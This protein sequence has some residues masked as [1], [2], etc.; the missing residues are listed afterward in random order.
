MPDEGNLLMPIHPMAIVDRQAEID[1]SADI[2]PY[3][4]IDGPVRIGP[5]TRVYPHAYVSGWTQIGAGCSIHPGA[6]VGHVP[7]DLAYQNERSFCRIGDG[8]IIREGAS[9]HRGTQRDSE[10]VV[11]RN[12]FIM[13]NAHV[14]HNCRVGDDVKMANAAVLAGH[15]TVGNGVFISSYGGI[16]QF[17]RIGELV[18]IASHT[19]ILMDVPPYFLAAGSGRCRGVNVVGMRR[20]ALGSQERLE[21]KRAYRVLYR[22]KL[23]F[24]D[25]LQRLREEMGTTPGKRILEFLS[26][27]SKRGIIGAA[28]ERSPI[29]SPDS[30]YAAEPPE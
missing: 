3:A 15:V 19:R 4:V 9:V 10:T 26:A 22:S 2:G 11:G 5:N 28:R 23:S 24:E 8:T 14:A 7:Q 25:A 30:E 20:A 29:E 13:S 1:P 17:T 12:C 21:V 16:H 18:M 27:P 6:V